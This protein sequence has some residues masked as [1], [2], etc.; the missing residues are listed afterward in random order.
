M[1]NPCPFNH[2]FAFDFEMY[3]DCQNGC[4]MHSTC[5]FEHEILTD[6]DYQRQKGAEDWRKFTGTEPP[7]VTG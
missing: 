1:N 5:F 3:L 7:E 6:A 4:D 2:N